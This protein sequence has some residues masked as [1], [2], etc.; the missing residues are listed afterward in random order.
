MKTFYDNK[1]SILSCKGF[2]IVFSFLESRMSVLMTLDVSFNHN[3]LA[4]SGSN[5]F[6]VVVFF[7]LGRAAVVLQQQQQQLLSDGRF[8][9]RLQ[10]RVPDLWLGLEQQL[11][12][13][14]TQTRL[15]CTKC[16]LFIHWMPLSTQLPL[17]SAC[18]HTRFPLVA[19]PQLL[20]P[21]GLY[22]VFHGVKPSAD[23]RMS[24]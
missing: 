5:I 22:C 7:V 20:G 13:N 16:L 10:L 23:D 19:T 17:L 2:Y 12:T 11:C 18:T 14:P 15:G 21:D 24:Y 4:S 8:I 3:K 9:R 6:F 1:S